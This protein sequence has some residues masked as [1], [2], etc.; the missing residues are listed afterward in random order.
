MTTGPATPRAPAHGRGHEVVGEVAGDPARQQVYEHG[1]QSWSPAGLYPATASS[2]RP[3]HPGSHTSGFR[4]HRTPPPQGFQGEGLLA[5]VADDGSARVWYAPD[6]WN[7]V[8]SVRAAPRPGATVVSA[9]GPVT[10]LAADSLDEALTRVADALAAAAGVGELR[11]L[12]PGWCSWYAYWGEVTE[13]DVLGNMG[14]AERLGLDLAVV[15]VDDGHQAAIGDWL[16]RSPRFGPLDELGSRIA[17]T[18][19]EPGIWTAPFLVAPDSDV[20]AAHPDWLLDGVVAL[21]N[22]GQDIRIL[23]VTHPDAAEHLSAVYRRLREQGFTYHK[24]D[25]LFAGAME[26][27]RQADAGGLDAYGLGLDI[28]REALGAE[29]TILGCGAPLLPS[30]GRVDAMRI[31]P[32]ID[33]SAEPV[34][35]DLSQPSQRGAV[36]AGA[37]RRWMHG[38]WWINDPDCILVRPQVEHRDAWARYLRDCGG[39]MM[40]SDPLDQ[41]DDDG[42]A[43]TRDLLRPSRPTPLDRAVGP[44]AVHTDIPD[45]DPL[46]HHSEP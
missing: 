24:L 18:G 29:A 30:I 39:L 5:V 13:A 25:F 37:A 21:H 44:S 1:W 35:G 12:G 20:A 2:P 38:R 14:A 3:R 15:Q 34:D 28:I 43:W 17:D 33:P 27:P 41:L 9:D 46:T 6:P 32:D 26:G 42:L 10:E 23:D 22:W 4:P 45:D 40:S 8:A 16:T 36:T 19:H 31:S 11:S 7:E